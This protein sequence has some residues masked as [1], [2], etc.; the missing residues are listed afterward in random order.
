MALEAGKFNIKVS[1]SFLLH[2][3]VVEGGRARE[4]MWDSEQWRELELL[5]LSGTD[6]HHNGINPFMGAEP[7]LPNH[8][9]KVSPLHTVALGIKFPTLELCPQ[10]SNHSSDAL[11]SEIRSSFSPGIGKAP[12]T[13][14]SYELLRGKVR[15]SF[16]DFMPCFGEEGQGK[17][18]DTFFF[19]GF[20]KF[21]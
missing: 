2:H 4:C 7:S 19:C 14:R 16:P 17:V 21:L 13:R 5:L 12:P 18:R 9:L 15:E 20:L 10:S 3:S 1:V 11:S 6:T 8:L